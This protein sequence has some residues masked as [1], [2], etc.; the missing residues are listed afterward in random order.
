MN[1]KV[2][3]EIEYIKSQ[4]M[5]LSQTGLAVSFA[6]DVTFIQLPSCCSIVKES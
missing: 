6:G 4:E 2:M 5:F 1:E 3:I